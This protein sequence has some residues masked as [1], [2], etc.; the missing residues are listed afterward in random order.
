MR[1][2]DFEAL[3]FD[4]FGTLIDWES[5]IV[6]A[7]RPLTAQLA[8]P[9]DRDRILEAHAHHESR[10]QAL[11][12][13]KRYQELLAVVYRRL[14]EDWGLAVSWH[15][16]LVYGRSVGQW[17]AFPDTPEA[18]AYLAR[19]HRLAVLSNVDNESFALASDKL[20]V[21]FDAVFTAED[22][23]SY[24]PSPRNF[25]YM[26]GELARRGIDRS[27]ILHVAESLF[28]DHGP[29]RRAGLAGCWIHRRHGQGGFGATMPPEDAARPALAF[30]SLADLVAAHRR[31]RAG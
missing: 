13:A 16:C 31:E 3:T 9:P 10:L 17:P 7:L 2:S 1:L 29:A 24:K 19:H 5:G 14:A 18:L 30:D 26:I 20:G 6:E 8:E 27:G 4:V 25:D 21:G 12:P 28:H 23:G 22:I 15:E 11:T